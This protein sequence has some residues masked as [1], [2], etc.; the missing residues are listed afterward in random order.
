V[1][2]IGRQLQ[3][4]EQIKQL[5]VNVRSG[6]RHISATAPQLVNP[7]RGFVKVRFIVARILAAQPRA[8]LPAFH[9]DG[10]HRHVRL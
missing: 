1:Q 2:A 8:Y 3:R 10:R 5:I 4:V 6:I 7:Q 9:R